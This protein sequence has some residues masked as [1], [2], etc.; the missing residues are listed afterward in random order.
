[1][2]DFYKNSDKICEYHD[3]GHRPVS[4]V[5]YEFLTELA[6]EPVTLEDFKQHVRVDYNMDDA[7][8]SIYLKAARQHLEKVAQKSFGERRVRMTALSMVDNWKVMYGP[9]A[10]VDAPY[11][12]FGKDII[13]N[14]GGTN[15]TITWS[16]SWPLGLPE[17][18]K[19]AIM[20]YGAGLYAIRENYILSVNGVIQEPTTYMDEAEKMVLK[21]GN[22]TFL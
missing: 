10:V 13:T 22:L 3:N 19:V 8:L 1:M 18:V 21:H 12:N 5:E 2:A 6:T 14:S 20:R 4:G 9:V 11:T 7:L 16:T 15:V 17:D